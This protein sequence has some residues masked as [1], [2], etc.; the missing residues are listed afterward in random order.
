MP[1]DESGEDRGDMPDFSDE[2]G[3]DRGIGEQLM[4]IEKSGEDRDEQDEMSTTSSSAISD[5]APL[6]LVDRLNIEC[7]DM[8][9]L[10]NYLCDDYSNI[11]V[12]RM[13]RSLM[14]S[15]CQDSTDVPNIDTV[16]TKIEYVTTKEV[17]AH[18]GHSGDPVY[19]NTSNSQSMSTNIVGS[20]SPISSD[21]R[22]WRRRPHLRL[23]LK[24][25]FKNRK[26][27]L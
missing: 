13:Q 19:A 14:S 7:L 16:T 15:S 4:K 18:E 12:T 10:T 5:P 17:L 23:M 24:I 26:I 11:D 25:V 9:L 21:G 27:L 22:R 2:R 3:K 1:T 20:V 8:L 6:A